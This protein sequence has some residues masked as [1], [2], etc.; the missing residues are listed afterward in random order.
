[1]PAMLTLAR[2]LRQDQAAV[3]AGAELPW[4]NGPVEG[5]VN[6]LKAIERAMYGRVKF[7]PLRARVL[8]AG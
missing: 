7:D 8:S 6:R 2:G 1:M 4:S 3:R 5:H